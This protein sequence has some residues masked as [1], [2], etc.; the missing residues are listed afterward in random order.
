MD[1]VIKNIKKES[2]IILRST[3]DI[4]SIEEIRSNPEFIEK[5]INLAYCPERIAEGMSIELPQIPQ[6]IGIYG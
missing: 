5:N 2:N 4:G 3:I 6:I 1:D